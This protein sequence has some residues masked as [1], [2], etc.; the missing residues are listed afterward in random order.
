ML[1]LTRKIGQSVV[2]GDAIYCT[3]FGYKEG[4]VKLGFDAP[5]II[6][7]H[8]EE[9][10]NRI[11]QEL[12]IKQGLEQFHPDQENILERLI[13]LLNRGHIA[14]SNIRLSA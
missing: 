3:V 8:R 7:V 9:I 12:Q 13:A 5:R 2:I 10:Q 14:H 1:V 11:W 4:E 6:P